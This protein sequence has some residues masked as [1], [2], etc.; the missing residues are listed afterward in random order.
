MARLDTTYEAEQVQ[1]EIFRQ[2]KPEARLQAGI[3]LSQTCR[4]LMETGVKLR[5]PEYNSN[6][7]QLAVIRLQIGQ[8]LFMKAYPQGKDIAP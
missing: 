2:M 3:A 6:Q 7:V 5:H 8:E 4:K 1:V